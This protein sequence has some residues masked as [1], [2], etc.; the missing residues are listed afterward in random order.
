MQLEN[1]KTTRRNPAS[2]IGLCVVL[3]IAIGSP[4]DT[5]GVAI[6]AAFGL[7]MGCIIILLGLHT[8]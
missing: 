1:K 6:G 3:G 2:V 8:T 5:K 4:W 7:F